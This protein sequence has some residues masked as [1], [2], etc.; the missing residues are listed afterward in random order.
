MT[1]PTSTPNSNRSKQKQ[2]SMEKNTTEKNI[3][4]QIE[5]DR[6]DRKEI[7]FQILLQSRSASLQSSSDKISMSSKDMKTLNVKA[8]CSVVL[9]C[10]SGSIVCKVWPSKTLTQGTASVHR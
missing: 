5:N 9:Q 2:K 1:T 3:N 10:S 6:N 7:L 4:I 8:G